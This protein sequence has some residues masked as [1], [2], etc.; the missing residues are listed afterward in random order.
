MSYTLLNNDEVLKLL[1]EKMN[2]EMIAAA[3]PIIEKALID[4]E[5]AMRQKLGSLVIS[6]LDESMDVDRKGTTLRILITNDS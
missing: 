6:M 2:R 4:I 5:K 3:Q 1:K